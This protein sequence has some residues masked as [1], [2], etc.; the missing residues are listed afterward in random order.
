MTETI[1]RFIKED[2]IKFNYSLGI[3]TGVRDINLLES[4]INAPFHSFGDV[5]L[6]P[7]ISDKAAR[8]L[9]GIAKNHPFVDGN[10]RTAFHAMS[11]FLISNGFK[12]QY[13]EEIAFNYLIKIVEQNLSV[14]QVSLWI[15]SNLKEL[16]KNLKEELFQ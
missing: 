5:E 3:S 14:K 2:L 8:L 15:R 1:I 10:K 6:F 4:A 12:L 13:S 9:I 16:P 7:F 11:V